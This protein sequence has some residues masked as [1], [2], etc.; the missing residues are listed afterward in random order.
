MW[1]S[2]VRFPLLQGIRRGSLAAVA[3]ALG[4]CG[5]HLAGDVPL[6]PVLARPYLSFVDPYSDFARSF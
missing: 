5:F 2:E 1:S 6:P 3:C 4:A